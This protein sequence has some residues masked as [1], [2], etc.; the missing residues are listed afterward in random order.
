M[1][2]AELD[3]QFLEGAPG[4]PAG[5]AGM[6]LQHQIERVRNADD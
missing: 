1:V 4:D 3:A 6:A 5:L 2:S